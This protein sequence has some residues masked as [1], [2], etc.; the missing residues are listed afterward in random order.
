MDIQDSTTKQAYIQMLIDTLEKKRKLLHWLTNV[1]EQQ[2]E[3]LNSE[4]FD[5]SLF[6]QTIS[7]KSEHL[8]NLTMLDQGFE[9]IYEGVREELSVNKSRYMEEINVLQGLIT[10]ITDLS[11]KLQVLEKRNKSRMDFVLSKKRKEIR[12]TRLSSKTVASYY[13]NMTQQNDIPSSL[14]Y[15]K[16]K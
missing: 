7:I 6:D 3:I 15:D 1:T 2:A 4:S 12:D 8:Q 10:D 13:K 9:R 16:K 14:F 5:S 11:V